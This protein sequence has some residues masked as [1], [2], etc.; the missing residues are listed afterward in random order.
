MK[1]LLIGIKTLALCPFYGW[2]EARAWPW[3][4]YRG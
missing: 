2:Q 4:V 1:K 3:T